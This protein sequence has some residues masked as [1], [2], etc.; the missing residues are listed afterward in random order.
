MVTGHS[1][2]LSREIGWTTNSDTLAKAN[3][4]PDMSLAAWDYVVQAGRYYHRFQLWSPT[5]RYDTSVA[6]TVHTTEVCTNL[7][8]PKLFVVLSSAPTPS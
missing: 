7:P 5:H 6:C 4:N 1:Q 3:Y 2:C 8:L